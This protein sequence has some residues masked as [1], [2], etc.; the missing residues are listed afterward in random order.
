MKKSELLN[1]CTQ[2]YCALGIQECLLKI[3]QVSAHKCIKN[4]SPVTVSCSGLPQHV[5][6]KSTVPQFLSTFFLVLA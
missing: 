4:K 6:E 3:S 1:K 2:T 5:C